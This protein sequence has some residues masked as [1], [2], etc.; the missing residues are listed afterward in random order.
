MRGSV[1][2][3]AL[4][5][6]EEEGEITPI[7]KKKSP[8]SRRASVDD[9]LIEDELDQVYGE[10]FMTSAERKKSMI[11]VSLTPYMNRSA[12][13]SHVS[14]LPTST[15]RHPF[16]DKCELIFFVLAMMALL[17]TLAYGGAKLDEEAVVENRDDNSIQPGELVGPVYLE[18]SSVTG[19]EVP[20][21][22][23]WG[24]SGTGT[25]GAK[26]VEV[27]KD[28]PPAEPPVSPT[29]S[30]PGDDIAQLLLGKVNQPVQAEDVQ[31]LLDHDMLAGI[32]IVDADGQLDISAE[33][34]VNVNGVEIRCGIMMDNVSL[35]FIC[36]D[37]S[38]GVYFVGAHYCD[39]FAG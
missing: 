12:L 29:L 30:T 15:R 21:A 37:S 33:N 2:D 32:R 10:V 28:P 1:K 17:G 19:G 5:G 25:D 18:D 3:L 8:R 16:W 35:T 24:N 13:S 20:E 4:N 26:Q 11:E 6:I 39:A 38:C 31:D 22:T 36:E 23:P 34:T 7:K 27:A 9:I 14:E